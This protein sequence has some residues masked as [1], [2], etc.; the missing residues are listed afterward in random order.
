MKDEKWLKASV[1][2]TVHTDLMTHK[3]IPDPFLD[4]NEKKVQWIENE[5][6]EYRSH[7]TITNKEWS[8]LN[9]VLIFEG[10]DAF[11]EI[12]I[13][14]RPLTK[15][16]NM[17]APEVVYLSDYLREGENVLTIRFT[18]GVKEGKE[19]AK[20][21]PFQLPESP[22]SLVR[23][24][25]YQFGW[26]WGPRWVTAGIWKDVKLITWDEATIENIR[27]EQK[28]ITDKKSDL[29]FHTEINVDQVGDNDLEKLQVSINGKIYKNLKLKRELNKVS[30]PFEIKKPKLW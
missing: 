3:I 30:F 12:H 29:V 7:F 8:N 27:V 28:S 14:G 15:T 10:L 25:Q 11:S 20:E 18:S 22:R 21:I 1:P 2:G 23:K 24:A 5:D 6:W 17:F 9:K 4:E 26:D 13:N 16:L 19:L